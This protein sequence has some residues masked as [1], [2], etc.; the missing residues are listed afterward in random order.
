M[1]HFTTTLLN[2]IL[3][4][5]TR[6]LSNDW[7]KDRK[8]FVAHTVVQYLMWNTQ[9]LANPSALGAIHKGRAAN[10]KFFPP[11]SLSVIVQ[12]WSPPSQL[13]HPACFKYM[14]AILDLS[15]L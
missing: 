11:P 15:P 3:N 13:G 2:H 12:I 1:Y 14:Y 4:E 8:Q 10:V 9:Y 6:F 5:I 7:F